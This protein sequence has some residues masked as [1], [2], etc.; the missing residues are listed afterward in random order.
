M[1]VPS[2]V[3]RGI[4]RHQAGATRFDLARYAPAAD[5]A[6]LV[7]HYW[8]VDWDLT[9]QEPYR[10]EVL[11]HPSVHL[12]FEAGRGEIFGVIRR[13]FTRRLQGRGRVFGIKF[14]PGAFFPFFGQPVSRL[15]DR[16]VGC[17]EVFGPAGEA[18]TATVLAQPDHG[19]MIAVVE[20]FLRQRLHRPDPRVL[21][22]GRLADRIMTDRSIRKVDDLLPDLLMSKRTLQRLFEQTVGVAPKW[23]IQRYRLHEAVERLN[24]TAPVDWPALALE[25]GYFDQSHFIHDFRDLVGCTPAAYAAQAR[26]RE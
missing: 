5:L 18:L 17:S 22:V 19:A 12:A 4:L 13:K 10:Q 8:T 1:R 7:E 3:P 6:P 11:S 23:L 21:E 2:T 15:T 20:P 24:A 14:R 16:I 25:L 26:S 9:G